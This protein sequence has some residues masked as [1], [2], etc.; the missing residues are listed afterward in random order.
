MAQSRS[1]NQTTDAEQENKAQP[2]DAID[3]NEI[4]NDDLPVFEGAIEPSL[5]DDLRDSLPEWI[6]EVIAI[7]LLIFGLLSFLA[8]FDTSGAVVAVAWANILK[9]LFG[10]GGVLVAGVLTWCC[11]L[12]PKNRD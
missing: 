7:S 9:S 6:D 10:Y 11:Y 12:T 1:V 3:K 2:S 5:W 4:S 8:L